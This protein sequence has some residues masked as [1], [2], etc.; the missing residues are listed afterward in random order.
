VSP[1]VASPPPRRRGRPPCCRREL[2]ILII[3]LRRR[4]LSYARIA[5][6]LNTAGIPTPEGRP[7][8]HREYVDRLL[9]TQYV[10]D[11]EAEAEDQPPGR[12]LTSDNPV[13]TEGLR[14][15]CWDYWV[16]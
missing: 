4:G 11:I 9:H 1:A 16:I 13:L 3:Q 10:R 8:W 12:E 14:T 5:D 15:S 6:L 2:A 7:L